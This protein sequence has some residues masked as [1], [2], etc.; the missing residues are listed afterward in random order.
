MFLELQVE[1]QDRGK[2]KLLRLKYLSLLEKEHILQFKSVHFL[3][4]F[5]LCLKLKETILLVNI[6]PILGCI[7]KKQL[8]L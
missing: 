7:L 2:Q 5:R 6:E 8:S 3:K 1:A 4:P